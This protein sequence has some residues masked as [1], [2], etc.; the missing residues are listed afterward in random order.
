M[1]DILTLG[2]Y[3]SISFLSGYLIYPVRNLIDILNEF[4]YSKNSIR[5][6]NNLLNIGEEKIFDEGKIKVTGN[7]KVK[8][9]SY[10]FNNKFYILNNINLFIKDKERV[11]LLGSSGSGKSTLLK[12]LYKYLTV[13]RDKI[14]INNYDINDYSLSDIRRDITYISQ[15]EMLFTGSIRDNI[16]LNRNIGEIDYLNICKLIYVDEIVK[17]NILGY[18][19][20]L[21]ENGINISGGQRQRIILARSLLKDC[22][23]IMIDEGLNQVDIKLEREVLKNIFDYFYDKTFIIVSHRKENID[24]YD[25]VIK[26][27]DGVVKEM[28]ERLTR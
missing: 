6:A 2:D 12:I 26:V 4:H 16:I 27:E 20:M 11:L 3:M 17:D 24:L 28:E 19:Y 7:I 23:I 1:N 10:T 18:D 9:L 5:R 15:N 22:N 13:E 21:E 25:R 8:N 14:F